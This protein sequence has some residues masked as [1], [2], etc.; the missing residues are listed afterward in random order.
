MSH[1][2]GQIGIEFLVLVGLLMLIFVFYVPIAWNQEKLIQKEREDLMAKTVAVT[3]KK[4]ID[5]AIT[6][7]SGYSR[8]FTLPSRII[9]YGYR[10]RVFNQSRVILLEWDEMEEMENIITNRVIGSPSP[11]TNKITNQGGTVVFE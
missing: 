10:I 2:K 7:G 4:E 1:T 3:V 6:F 9:D 5:M 11:G 8:N